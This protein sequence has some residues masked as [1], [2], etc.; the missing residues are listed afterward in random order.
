MFVITQASANVGQICMA[1][2][3]ANASLVS[4]T[5]PT[6]CDASAMDMLT[7]VIY[8]LV[9]VLIAV[10]TPMAHIA[11]GENWLLL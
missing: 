5:S 9:L 8:L 6:V 2:I 1:E 11:I 3:V 10:T 4:G 7:L